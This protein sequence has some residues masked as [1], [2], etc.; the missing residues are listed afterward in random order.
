MAKKTTNTQ[1]EDQLR[2]EHTHMLKILRRK[3]EMSEALNKDGG[4]NED[5]ITPKNK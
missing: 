4:D 1:T 2:K 3:R 5:V